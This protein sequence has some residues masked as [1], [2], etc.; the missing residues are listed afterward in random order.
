M[1][2]TVCIVSAAMVAVACSLATPSD[3]LVGS[4]DAGAPSADGATDDVVI[5]PPEAGAEIAPD[6]P[7]ADAGL[8]CPGT[9]GPSMTRIQ[10]GASTFCID[11]TEVTREQ[12]GAFLSTLPVST[13]PRCAFNT[14]FV[15]TRRWPATPTTTK[16][17]VV[18]VD[19][20]D[21]WQY[22]VSVGKKLCGAIAGGPID[23]PQS[24]SETASQI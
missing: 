23:L 2:W 21:A 22:C 5:A 19:W 13:H 1:R 10:A 18:G 7:D 4:P 20:C 8:P 9:G 3:D 14:S 6:P 17:P 12:Y 16:H 24:G 11:S 15:P